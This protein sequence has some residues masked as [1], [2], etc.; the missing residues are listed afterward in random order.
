MSNYT[1]DNFW[2][3][4]LESSTPIDSAKLIL[5]WSFIENGLDTFKE[6]PLTLSAEVG[7]QDDPAESALLLVSAPGAVGKTTLAKQI[8]FATG[9]VYIDLSIA[10]PVGANTLIGDIANSGLYQ[11]WINGSVAVLIDGLDEARLKVTQEA[12]DAFL[13]D[14]ATQSAGRD[15]PTVL[16]GRTGAIIHAQDDCKVREFVRRGGRWSGLS[17]RRS[18]WLAGAWTSGVETILPGSERSAR[19]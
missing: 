10:A 19:C 16:F 4:R 13:L 14:V 3:Q 2:N 7:T 1:I 11:D 6:A 8:A 17:G 18:S 9:S 12:F 5:G 15:M